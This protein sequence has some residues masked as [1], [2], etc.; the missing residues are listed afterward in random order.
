MDLAFLAFNFTLTNNAC[1]LDI[2]LIFFVC[3]GLLQ[4]VFWGFGNGGSCIFS[5]ALYHEYGPIVTFQIFTVGAITTLGFVV[6]MDKIAECYN[7]EDLALV[8]N[9]LISEECLE[10]SDNN[11]DLESVG[12]VTKED[13]H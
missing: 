3:A 12:R 6:S 4:S 8:E 13:I 2:F 10:G 1:C 11:A 5:G 7:I 9:E